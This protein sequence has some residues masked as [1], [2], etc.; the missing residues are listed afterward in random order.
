MINSDNVLLRRP[1]MPLDHD[2]SRRAAPGSTGSPSGLLAVTIWPLA[3]ATAAE[4]PCALP[5][6]PRAGAS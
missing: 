3:Q 4:V 5:E 6:T 2:R 1:V